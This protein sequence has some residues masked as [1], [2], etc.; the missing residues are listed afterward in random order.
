[1][2]HILISTAALSC[3]T[4]NHT[5][6]DGHDLKPVTSRNA[7]SASACCDLCTTTATCN[8]WTFI[9][10]SSVCFLKTSAAGIRQFE[11]YVSGCKAGVSCPA[12]PPPPPPP[13][14]PPSPPPPPAPL[15]RG[16]G[17][18]STAWDCSLGGE[19]VSSKCACDAQYTG[20][21]CAVLRLKPA[22]LS[23]SFGENSTAPDATHHWGG[24]AI[25]DNS[26]KKW[27]GFFSYMAEYCDLSRWTSQ[28]MII[29][30]VSDA[31]D[32]PFNQQR[33]PV[34]GP[35]THNAMISQHP[36]GTYFLFH[37]GDGTP[38][39]KA[40]SCSTT[41]KVDP[42]FPFPAGHP[43]PAPATTHASDS[44][45]GPWRAASN[46]PGVNNPAVFFWPNGTAAIYDRTSV[47][48]S[49]SIDGPWGRAAKGQRTYVSQGAG[50]GGT[51]GF[52]PEDPFV[53]KDNK[54]RFHMLINSNS[55]HS[56]CAA[57][58]PCG[59]HLWSEDGLE[60]SKPHTP[61]FGTIVHMADG[62]TDV[63]DYCERPQ[64]AQTPDGTPLTF[65]FGHGY[66]K[67]E[68][69][70]LMFCQDGDADADCV[71]TVE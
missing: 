13:R 41:G 63:Y 59:G 18:C 70:A 58:V 57:K 55:G 8:V 2:I 45:Y 33:T 14:P 36:N 40:T 44:L 3:V 48:W 19:C 66:S 32:G 64:I 34:T 5:D 27:V 16:G 46:I 71:T 20:A 52:N 21:H 29:S 65:Y 50:S 49:D 69:V 37:I 17:A 23:N 4:L 54:N 26:T 42:V 25:Q 68:N 51:P 7:K 15:V 53:W 10:H 6:F 24:H 56:N 11:D 67:V 43:E 28:S 31:P 62:T 47:M 30:A 12:G 38:K 39:S 1:M 35:W 61:A 9:P 22:K 60:W